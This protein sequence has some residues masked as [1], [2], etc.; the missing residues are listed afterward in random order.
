MEHGH[1]VPLLLPTRNSYVS[2]F[3]HGADPLEVPLLIDENTFRPVGAVDIDDHYL[4][5]V[6]NSDRRI[7]CLLS[8]KPPRLWDKGPQCIWEGEAAGVGSSIQLGQFLWFIRDDLLEIRF[9]LRG[10]DDF[11]SISTDLEGVQNVWIS[12]GRVFVLSNFGSDLTIYSLETRL[13]IETFEAGYKRQIVGYLEGP[14]LADYRQYG[15]EAIVQDNGAPHI[16]SG[17][18]CRVFCVPDVVA[19]VVTQFGSTQM[20][21]MRRDDDWRLVCTVLGEVRGLGATKQ[22][23]VFLSMSSGANQSLIAIET[24]DTR[25]LRSNSSS[26]SSAWPFRVPTQTGTIEAPLFTPSQ[27]SG[28]VVMIHGGPVEHVTLAESRDIETIVSLG[29]EVIAPNYSGSTGYGMNHISRLVGR[30]GEVDVE[31]VLSAISAASRRH[32]RGLH[33]CG[34]SYGAHLALRALASLGDT[35]AIETIT[36]VSGIPTLTALHESG[37]PPQKR[38]LSTL[39][40]G[41]PLPRNEFDFIRAGLERF[42]GEIMVIYGEDDDRVPREIR[43]VTAQ[44]IEGLAARTQFIEIKGGGH[45]VMKEALPKIV[46]LIGQPKYLSV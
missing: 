29:Y 37:A 6:M 7:Q 45:Y 18:V 1:R 32:A 30:L 4:A 39:M 21:H 8:P 20:V 34:I 3:T 5:L 38:L 36:L 26:V 42:R 22:G 23:E 15:E 25:E 35:S 46:E 14:I 9:G 31:D 2:S 43:Q 10:L 13:K 27:G 28:V 41:Q 24:G 19:V 40:K 16:L 11:T 44:L 12:S 17:R 33:L